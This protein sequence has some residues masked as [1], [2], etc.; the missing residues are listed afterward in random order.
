MTLQEML[1]TIAENI[2]EHGTRMEAQALT[3]LAAAVRDTQPG[4]A[5]ALSDWD[6]AE[7]ARLRAFAVIHITVVAAD[8]DRQRSIAQSVGRLLPVAL[9]A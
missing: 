5:S 8:A 9:A 6:G 1:A 4:A 7:V 3:A 2:A